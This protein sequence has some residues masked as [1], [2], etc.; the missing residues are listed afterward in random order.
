MATKCDVATW[1]SVLQATGVDI[2]AKDKFGNFLLHQVSL[3]L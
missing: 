2:N 1:G 3:A